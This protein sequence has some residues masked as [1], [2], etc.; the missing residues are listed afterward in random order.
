MTITPEYLAE[1]KELCEKATLG[2]WSYGLEMIALQPSDGDFK[3]IAKRPAHPTN[4]KNWNNDSE[5]IAAARE[6]LPRLIEEVES[7]DREIAIFKVMN[8]AG[9]D[10]IAEMSELLAS[11]D[12]QLHQ[13]NMDLCEAN[14]LAEFLRD[15]I[16][17]KDALFQK[18]VEMA[19]FYSKRNE[20][21]SD[22]VLGPYT[23]V[24]RLARA[25]LAEMEKMK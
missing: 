8:S 3:V 13:A 1:L 6:A 21:Y 9:D 16:A 12:T 2:P 17:A 5:F 23:A 24:N 19:E 22:S 10:T 11:K 20:T 4:D 15:K 7:K 25:F 14:D 18:A